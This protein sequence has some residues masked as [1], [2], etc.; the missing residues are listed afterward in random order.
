VGTA[1]L[2]TIPISHYCEKA[3]W[4]L[5]CA[6]I[7]YVEEPH[8]QGAHQ[9]AARRAGAGKTV[10][11]LVTADGEVIAESAAIL[12]YADRRVAP[13]ARLFA[14]GAEGARARALAAGWNARLGVDGRRW[15]YAQ[16]APVREVAA[17][18]DLTGVPRWERMAFR[19]ALPVLMWGIN[20]HINVRPEVVAQS[21]RAVRES[22]D[23]VG[24][25]LSDG[26]QYLCGERFGGAD[27]T[28]AALAAALVLPLEYGTKLPVVED[29]P[30][31]W[32]AEVVRLRTH[33]A[34]AFALR[35]YRDE[36][37]QTV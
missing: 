5:E 2:L 21:L 14:P 17:T 35:M 7:G 32:A 3:R 20:R 33:P 4:A 27:L 9:L 29:L 10:P 36:R 18:M 34:G 13:E 25:L 37:R 28:F 23:A 1:R 11:V 15:M 31:G 24:A 6:G 12:D 19:S 30:A 22:F 8:I 16:I 26:R